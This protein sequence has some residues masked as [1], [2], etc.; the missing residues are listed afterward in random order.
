MIKW[1]VDLT[2]F[3]EQFVGSVSRYFTGRKQVEGKERL[4]YGKPIAKSGMYFYGI[5]EEVELA[6]DLYENLHTTILSTARMKFWN[7]SRGEGRD[8]CT[9]FVRGLFDKLA[10]AK[11]LD[12]QD[13]TTRGLIVQSG[14]IAKG[15]QDRGKNWLEKVKKIKLRQGSRNYTGTSDYSAYAEGREDGKRVNPSID[16]KNKLGGTSKFLQ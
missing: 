5:A 3:V 11:R 16:R 4:K 15:K 6:L 1:E 12:S 7:A 2:G 9:G 8:Y 10:E 13:S 14:L